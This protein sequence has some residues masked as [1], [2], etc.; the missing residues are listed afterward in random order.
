MQLN[1]SAFKYSQVK[2]H[3]KNFF[4]ACNQHL[5]I[6]ETQLYAGG[7]GNPI[8]QSHPPYFQNFPVIQSTDHVKTTCRFSS[9]KPGLLNTIYLLFNKNR[10]SYVIH[11]ITLQ[12]MYHVL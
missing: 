10:T 3:S 9:M 4:K 5:I 2:N 1:S 6:K 8:M 11:Y 7:G 12:P